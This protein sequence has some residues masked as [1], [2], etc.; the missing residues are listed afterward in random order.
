MFREPLTENQV[1]VL[2]SMLEEL[3]AAGLGWQDQFVQC[4]MQGGLFAL[5]TKSDVPK[6]LCASLSPVSTSNN[7]EDTRE[8]ELN[9]MPSGP[10]A[11]VRFAPPSVQDNTYADELFYPP[12]DKKNDRYY[13]QA[14]LPITSKT[15]PHNLELIQ[16]YLQPI[17]PISHLRESERQRNFDDEIALR[18][19]LSAELS[20]S[21][22]ERGVAMIPQEPDYINEDSFG[23]SNQYF[24]DLQKRKQQ[25]LASHFKERQHQL[26]EEEFTEL[27]DKLATP[28]HSSFREITHTEHQRNPLLDQADL[29]LNNFHPKGR[30]PIF[31]ADNEIPDSY[32]PL[33]QEFDLQNDQPYFEPNGIYT[34]GGVVYPESQNLAFDSKEEARNVLA[35]ILGFTRHERLD[36]KKPGPLTGPPPSSQSPEEP[37]KTLSKNGSINAN[38]T[39]DSGETG[40]KSKKVPNVDHSTNNDHAPHSVDTAYAHV[41]LRNALD[42]WSEGERVITILAQTLGM[43]PYFTRTRVDRHEVSFFVEPNPDKKSASD[44]SKFLNDPRLKSNISRRY[45]IIIEA[46]GVGDKTKAIDSVSQKHL[47][48][49]LDDAPDVTHVMAY[50]FAGAGAAAAIVI[51]ITLFL[52]KRHDKKKDKL[53]GL[54]TGITGT[55]TCSKDYQELCRAR[56][57]GKG[58]TADSGRIT[59]LA[60][61]SE[62]PPSSRSSTSS[63]SEEPAL[64]NMDISTGHMVL[65]SKI[66]CN[67]FME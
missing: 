5:R 10:E 62:R 8:N 64:T 45:G 63:W 61:E 13:E 23:E 48:N 52:I 57:A 21:P 53:S 30:Y 42:S 17:R 7:R 59:S 38:M 58:T 66:K 2:R 65:V 9:S 27:L 20:E 14:P 29:P 24:S 36:V 60:K 15:S 51:V 18:R 22:Y 55:E 4:R 33:K 37:P 41:R 32:Y 1:N 19:M 39:V 6:N 49:R 3:Q 44:V 35:D 16:E 28:Q 67:D 46:A 11:F 31:E 47:Q 12:I 54:P 26:E 43:E 34:E 40:P 56:M 50:M 25:N